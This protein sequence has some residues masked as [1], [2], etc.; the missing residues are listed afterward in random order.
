MLGLEAVTH[1]LVDAKAEVRQRGA[2]SIAQ[3][4]AALF[5]EQPGEEACRILLM[6]RDRIQ[7]LCLSAVPPAYRRAGMLAVRATLSGLP[8]RAFPGPVIRGYTSLVV[9][10]VMDAD[11]V[12]RIAAVEAV[13][14]V[15]RRFREQVVELCF[16]DLFRALAC[17]VNDSDARVSTLGQEVSL[18]V[19]EAVSGKQPCAIRPADFASFLTDTL[20]LPVAEGAATASGCPAVVAWAM[21]WTQFALDMPG[22][23]MASCLPEILPVLLRVAS[24]SMMSSFSP[25]HSSLSAGGGVTSLPDA[26]TRALRTCQSLLR[27]NLALHG[28]APRLDSVISTLLGAIGTS[29]RLVAGECAEKGRFVPPTPAIQRLCLEWIHE[30]VLLALPG[31]EAGGGVVR[32]TV[33][34]LCSAILQTVLPYLASPDAVVRQV[35][36]ATHKDLASV[37][38]VT[39]P[40][41]G[42]DDAVVQR[43]VAATCTFFVM[44][45]PLSGPS[46]A[47]GASPAF[48][49]DTTATRRVQRALSTGALSEEACLGGLQWFALLFQLRKDAIL[50]SYS[51]VRGIVIALLCGPS[52]VVS[53]AAA[54]VLCAFVGDT[55]DDSLFQDAIEAV[56]TFAQA[57]APCVLPR[58]PSIMKALQARVEGVCPDHGPAVPPRCE[59]LLIAVARVLSSMGGEGVRDPDI[60]RDVRFTS[61]CVVALNSLVLTSEEFCG[62]RALLRP[63][64]HPAVLVGDAVHIATHRRELV[65]S[66]LC[67][68]WQYSAVPLLSLCLLCSEDALALEV[69]TCMSASE[70]SPATLVQ[71]DRMVQMLEGP[72]FAHMRLR[73]LR[74]WECQPLV[75]TL[76]AVLMLLPQVSPQY[77][78][79]HRRLSLVSGLIQL[80]SLPHPSQPH[81]GEGNKGAEEERRRLLVTSF[82][83]CQ[84]R[85]LVAEAKAASIGD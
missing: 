49:V 33:E 79:L 72:V 5:R 52:L 77:D 11:P 83:A 51:T 55:G 70:A 37:L 76:C 73:L 8:L 32:A 25:L 80:R 68:A 63:A 16:H 64:A 19:K 48:C 85:V 58:L 62:L 9:G 23:D 13:H 31:P 6:E 1:L 59:R 18:S 35:A 46:H 45:A 61:K 67:A 22:L 20:Q 26:A 84:N 57:H 82:I 14:E 29:N 40:G 41:N 42:A 66:E 2:N 53:R 34:E 56:L 78:S 44:T 50:R 4:A 15:V 75:Q 71:L 12:V 21:D 7:H 28:Q 38:S 3:R 17:V 36:E 24:F 65:F 30:L 39:A 43:L 74:P 60:V 10:S 54:D 27:K 47:L 81:D 69:C